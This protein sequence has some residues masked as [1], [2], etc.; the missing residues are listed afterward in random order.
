MTARLVFIA[1]MLSGFSMLVSAAG[2]PNL[3]KSSDRTKS[4]AGTSARGSNGASGTSTAQS[5]NAR[6]GSHTRATTGQV[7]PGKDNRP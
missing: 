1:S 3:S 4:E 2:D 7:R 5:S 6:M